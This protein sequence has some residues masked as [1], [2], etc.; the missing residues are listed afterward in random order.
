MGNIKRKTNRAGKTIVSFS[1]SSGKPIELVLRNDN[2]ELRINGRYKNTLIN[3]VTLEQAQIASE[4]YLKEYTDTAT[5]NLQGQVNAINEDVKSLKYD[6]DTNGLNLYYGSEMFFIKD[7][8]LSIY[9][10]NMLADNYR[11]VDGL[12]FCSGAIVDRGDA[13]YKNRFDLP[14]YKYIEKHGEVLFPNNTPLYIWTEKNETL[15]DNFRAIPSRSYVT[16]LATKPTTHKIQT[17]GSSTIEYGMTDY[18]IRYM[19]SNGVTL[20]SCGQHFDLL[21]S[22]TEGRS[23]W[24]YE[25]FTGRERHSTSGDYAQTGTTDGNP[26]LR[27]ADSTDKADY[28]DYCFENNGTTGVQESYTEA[29]DKDKDFYI[30]DYDWYLS[31]RG[32]STPDTIVIVLGVNGS[33]ENFDPN[34]RWMISRIIAAVPTIKIG[35]SVSQQLR[36]EIASSAYTS[37]LVAKMNLLTKYIKELNSPNITELSLHAHNNSEL[38]HNITQ[39]NTQDNNNTVTF[40]AT[41][42]FLHMQNNGYLECSKYIGAY[43]AYT[44]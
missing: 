15:R 19:A 4:Q 37:D 21:G 23:G 5:L 33:V 35:L 20:T 18:I 2:L 6:S 36:S 11:K 16:D 1:D 41:A 22:I 17:I 10:R 32:V 29:V 12:W 44:M 13:T 3:D 26:F 8:P 43:I 42:D 24:S 34:M 38:S 27:L 9:P 28:P 40:N 39:T 31:T 14:I 30:F 7:T 25:V